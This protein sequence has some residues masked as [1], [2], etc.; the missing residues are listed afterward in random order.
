MSEGSLACSPMETWD[1][2][3]ENV[4]NDSKD[5][6][7]TPLIHLYLQ[8][9]ACCRLRKRTTSI[10]HPKSVLLMVE[11]QD[12]QE[13]SIAWCDRFWPNFG[14]KMPKFISLHDVRE[15]FIKQALLASR[16]VIIAGQI[17]GSKLRRVFTL[18]GDG[19][20]LPIFLQFSLRTAFRFFISPRSPASFFISPPLSMSHDTSSSDSCV[21]SHATSVEFHH[22]VQT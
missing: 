2:L 9:F 12:R 16:D 17:C 15:S 11:S 10:S 13:A 5:T 7:T 19:C 18:L 14:Q 8:I 20:S 6:T 4:P 21:N 22:I 3:G 1:I